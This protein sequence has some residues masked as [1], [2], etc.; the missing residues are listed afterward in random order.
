MCLIN[1]RAVKQ[2][3]IRPNNIDFCMFHG[4]DS[5]VN[6]SLLIVVSILCKG[7]FVFGFH[8]EM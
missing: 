6:E 5:A 1:S 3:N 8:F 2:L 7:F 4:F